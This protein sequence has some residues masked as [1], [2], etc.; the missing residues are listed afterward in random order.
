MVV[1]NLNNSLL[2]KRTNK[3][4][5]HLIGSKQNNYEELFMSKKLVE[6]LFIKDSD[7]LSILKSE[8]NREQPCQ[9]YCTNCGKLVNQHLRNI[10]FLC[11]DCKTKSFCLEKYGVDNPSKDPKIIEI[12]KEKSKKS[13]PERFKKYKETC[14]KLYGVDNTFKSEKVKQKIKES[15]IKNHGVEHPLQSEVLKEKFIKTCNER[16]GVDY[17]SQN[18][19]VR[20]SIMKR[21]TYRNIPF[22]SSWELAYYIYLKDNN[23][24]FTYQPETNL[25][26]YFNGKKHKYNPDFKIGDEI[27][28]IKGEQFY[29]MNTEQFQS[30][31]KL[32]NEISVKILRKPDILPYLKYIKEK[33]GKNYLESFRNK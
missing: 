9:F 21:Y 19:N 26:Y 2:I 33:Y 12:I 5:E 10:T 14:M 18:P 27:I 8:Y 31:L 3:M 32:M 25:W 16:F 28:E 6:S 17:P 15:M 20:N 24:D 4:V 13:N 30:K 7:D 1:I 29:R 23:I 11:K 22:D